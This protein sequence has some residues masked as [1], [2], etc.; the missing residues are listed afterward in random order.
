M[1]DDEQIMTKQTSSKMHEQRGMAS[2][3]PTVEGRHSLIWSSVLSIWHN[4]QFP[5]ILIKFDNEDALSLT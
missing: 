3:D 5:M 2:E 1:R 4:E